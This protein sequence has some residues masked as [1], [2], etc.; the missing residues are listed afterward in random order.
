MK[1]VVRLPWSTVDG[2]PC[3]T[4]PA[5]DGHGTGA[6]GAL[7]D[8]WEAAQVLQARSVLGAARV[9]LAPGVRVDG[10]RLRAVFVRLVWSLVRMVKV[11]ESRG[12]RLGR[13]DAG[14]AARVEMARVLLGHTE[15]LLVTGNAEVF[16][17][18]YVLARLVECLAAMVEIAEARGALL[19]APDDGGAPD[20]DGARCGKG[21]CG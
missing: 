21:A 18:R 7:A 10:G 16:Q 6:V 1:G 3:Y 17:L 11:A 8:V 19:A 13:S 14:E 9:W 4:V 15:D 2:T 20:G 5:P 12:Q